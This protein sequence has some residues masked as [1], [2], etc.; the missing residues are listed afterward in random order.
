[1]PVIKSPFPGMDPFLQLRWDEMHARLIHNAAD[2]LQS[3][4]PEDLRARIE[5]RVFVE[6]GH[7]E[8]R[9]IVPDVFVTQIKRR[10]DTQIMEPQDANTA[11]AEPLIFTLPSE[12]EIT[13]GFL[14]IRERG[15]GNSHERRPGP[16]PGAGRGGP[17][18]HALHEGSAGRLPRGGVR[19]G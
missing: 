15:G 17:G 4:L 7:E 11:V 13:Q 19:G 2:A 16:G 5:A 12:T 10:P 3:G 14:E 8:G 1:M 18:G 6:T 9:E